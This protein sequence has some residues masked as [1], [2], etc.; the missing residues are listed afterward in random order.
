MPLRVLDLVSQLGLG[1]DRIAI[2]SEA[3]GQSIDALL[4]FSEM[5]DALLAKK[6]N[7]MI[8]VRSV[9]LAQAEERDFSEKTHRLAQRA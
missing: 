4:P 8:L 9:T 7:S 1:P 2:E 3:D 5:R 6:L